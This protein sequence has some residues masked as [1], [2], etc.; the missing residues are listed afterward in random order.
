MCIRDRYHGCLTAEG[1]DD[2][3]ACVAACNAPWGCCGDHG[4]DYEYQCQSNSCGGGGCCIASAGICHR[5]CDYYY[6]QNL[7]VS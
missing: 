1:S 4:A 6:D 3:A 5:A 2:H 7:A